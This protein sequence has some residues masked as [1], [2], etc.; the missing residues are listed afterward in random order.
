M[1]AISRRELG[2][3]G[4]GPGSRLIRNP[5]RF[6]KDQINEANRESDTSATTNHFAIICAVGV[7]VAGDRTSTTNAHNANRTIS[8]ASFAYRLVIASE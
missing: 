5:S 8:I 7:G 6:V 1:R 3:V 4:E 2:F